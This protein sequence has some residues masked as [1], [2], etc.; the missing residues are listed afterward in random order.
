MQEV[1]GARMAPSW[2]LVLGRTTYERFS[3]YWPEQHGN[4][5]SE[6]L[7]RVDKY[8][9]SSTLTEPLAWQNSTLLPGDAADAVSQLKEQLEENLTV[10]GSGV[11]VRSLLRRDLVD[12][13]VL[14][15]HPL[16]LGSGRRLFSDA[17]SQLSAFRLIDAVT[18]GT[19]VII[20]TYQPAKG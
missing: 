20:A 19:G 9:A 1:M 12:E 17:G 10:W 16:V 5:F 15:V 13:L 4:P 11:L 6:A 2:V 8:V 7:D 3:T 14:M 18:T